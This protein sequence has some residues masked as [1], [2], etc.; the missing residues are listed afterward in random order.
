MGRA[1]PGGMRRDFFAREADG[2]AVVIDVRPDDRV[3]ARDAE[4]FAVTAEACEAAGWEYRRAG[5]LDPVVVANVRW[6]SR[7]R[8]RRC[9]VPGI[10]GALL[11]AFAGGRGLFEGAELAGDRLRALPVL[12]HLMWQ[13]EL[14]TFYRLFG[15]LSHG[16][17]VTGSASTRRSL[18]GRPKGTFGSL[19]VAAPGEVVQMDSSPLDVLVLLDDGV[20]GRVDMTGMIDVATRVVP[21]A[22]LR[23]TTKSVDAS[24]LLAPALTPEPVRPGWPDA[25]RM[26]RSALP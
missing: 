20:P 7:Y 23:P 19:A 24:V 26:A 21:A 9:L 3:P 8:H 10:A 6:L 14:A 17:H 25:L 15:T 18:A 5:D 13:R 1:G 11:E 22:V 4:T 12:F 16:R 2:T